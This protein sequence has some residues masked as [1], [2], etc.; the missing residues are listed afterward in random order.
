MTA[1]NERNWK[2]ISK[3]K[4]K[5]SGLWNREYENREVRWEDW[6]NTSLIAEVIDD[7]QTIR[8]I[9]FRVS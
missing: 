8:S 1:T 9:T 4:D 2:R 7:G 3:K 6:E 5:K